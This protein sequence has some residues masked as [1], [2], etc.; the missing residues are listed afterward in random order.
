MSPDGAAAVR[1][2]GVER[3]IYMHLFNMV[4]SI[5]V[6]RGP[7]VRTGICRNHHGLACASGFRRSL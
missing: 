7:K 5:T 1:G 4:T 2:V 3:W 6:E